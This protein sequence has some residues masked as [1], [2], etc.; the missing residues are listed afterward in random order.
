MTN[1]HLGQP[2]EVSVSQPAYHCASL[3]V[4]DVESVK[5]YC[6]NLILTLNVNL[7]VGT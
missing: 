2:V 6:S 7:L 3:P 4:V 1:F 5:A